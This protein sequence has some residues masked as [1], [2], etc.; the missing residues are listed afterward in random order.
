MEAQLRRVCPWRDIVRPAEGGEEVIQ[1]L[2][3]GQVDYGEAQAPFITVA[4]EQVVLA[5]AGVEQ[6]AG[7][8]SLR[9]V[10][11]VFL[12]YAGDFDEAGTQA[13]RVAGSQRG[14]R[15][16]GGGGL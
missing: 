14:T 15:G 9:I 16:A 11:V 8:D 5:D 12:A 10:V 2:A 7:G 1:R 13:G 4:A 6:V 3:I